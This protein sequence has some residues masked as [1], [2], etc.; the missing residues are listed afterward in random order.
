[1]RHQRQ[2][3]D[4]RKTEDLCNEI[5]NRN[6]KSKEEYYPQNKT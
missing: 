5:S 2:I 1:M 6:T 3:G 4:L